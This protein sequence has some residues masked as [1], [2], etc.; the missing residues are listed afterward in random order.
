MERAQVVHH[1][2]LKPYTLP[3]PTKTVPNTPTV[4][5][6]PPVVRASPDLDCLGGGVMDYGLCG[7]SPGPIS[8][9]SRR[10]RVVRPP[11]HFQD[12]VMF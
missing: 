10:G 8:G 9:Q 4:P 1:D 11:L 5:M 7:D 3:L 12:F 6:S 2:K